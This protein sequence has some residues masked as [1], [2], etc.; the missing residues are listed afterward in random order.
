MFFLDP[1][2]MAPHGFTTVDP[3]KNPKV[4]PTRAGVKGGFFGFTRRYSNGKAK[5]HG[6]VD[7]LATRGTPLKSIKGGIVTNVVNRVGPGEKGRVGQETGNYVIIKSNLEDGS[8]VYF[9]YSHLDKINVENGQE[10]GEGDVFGEAGTSGNASGLPE[11]RQHVHIEASTTSQFYP[12]KG[13]GGTEK[14]TRIDPL[15]FFNSTFDQNGNS[16]SPQPITPP[17]SGS[18]D[19]MS[20]L[21]EAFKANANAGSSQF[22]VKLPNGETMKKDDSFGHF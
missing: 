5:F 13:N 9:K 22:N 3:V 8:L 15:Q 21:D 19:G 14:D 2:G 7:I 4:A 6:G 12:G 1:D 11:E 16:Q 20:P 17:V 18:L 10:I